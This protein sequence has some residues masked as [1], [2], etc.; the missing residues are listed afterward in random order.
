MKS[1]TDGNSHATTYQYNVSGEL[2]KVTN[3]GGDT[4]QYAGYDAMGRVGSRT[5]GNGLVTTYAYNGP[6]KALSAVSYSSQGANNIGLSYDSFGRLTSRTDGSGSESY[7][8]DSLSRLVSFTTSY[9]GLAAKAF[10][11]AYNPNGSVHQMLGTTGKR[12]DRNL[13]RP[14][15]SAALLFP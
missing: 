7:V 3:P 9:T 12:T 1:V 8:Y 13:M 11:F 4:V 10:S 15:A 14:K 5:D 2:L 6:G